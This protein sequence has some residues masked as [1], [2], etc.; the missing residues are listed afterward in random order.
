LALR[1]ETPRAVN[2]HQLALM[3]FTKKLEPKAPLFVASDRIYILHDNGVRPNGKPRNPS[4]RLFMKVPYKTIRTFYKG[5]AQLG[6]QAS[7]SGDSATS[8]NSVQ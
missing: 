3:E 8:D 4:L 1:E 5:A 7:D 6:R 2:L